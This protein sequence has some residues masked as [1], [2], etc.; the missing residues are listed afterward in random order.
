MK[1]TKHE[2]IEQ[3]EFQEIE[4]KIEEPIVMHEPMVN[5]QTAQTP[6]ERKAEDPTFHTPVKNK[7][8]NRT[9]LFPYKHKNKSK[10]SVMKTPAAHK[11]EERFVE[12]VDMEIV[13]RWGKLWLRSVERNKS[14]NMMRHMHNM[15]KNMRKNMEEGVLAAPGSYKTNSIIKK[16]K[17]KRK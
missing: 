17:E 15:M 5:E 4:W 11:V 14:L 12:S 13:T 1:R 10:M 8:E 3:M 2:V 7:M 9:D 16:K 6:V